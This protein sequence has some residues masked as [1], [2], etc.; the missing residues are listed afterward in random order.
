MDRGY[1]GEQ[2]YTECDSRDI[3]SVIALK[4]TPAVKARKHRPGHPRRAGRRRGDA[5]GPATAKALGTDQARAQPGRRRAGRPQQGTGR[6]GTGR[7]IL[8]AANP[9]AGR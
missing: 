7:Q 8:T 3:R 4:E 1:D 2:M 5:A 9:T 6:A